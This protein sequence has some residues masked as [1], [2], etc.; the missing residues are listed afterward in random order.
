MGM[1]KFFDMPSK[2]P[3]ESLNTADRLY[4]IKLIIVT[5]LFT[6]SLTL[7][8]VQL[9]L[10]RHIMRMGDNA[11]ALMEWS[12]KADLANEMLNDMFKVQQTK[13]NYESQGIGAEETIIKKEPKE[14]LNE[15][16]N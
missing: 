15:K 2:E 9:M 8:G 11:K 4:L 13:E 12:K 14:V 1:F 5:G 6:V 10:E 3:G 7:L 16:Q